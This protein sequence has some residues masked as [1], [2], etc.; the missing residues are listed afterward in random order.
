MLFKSFRDNKIDSEYIIKELVIEEKDDK[1]KAI[2]LTPLGRSLR[3]ERNL[4]QRHVSEMF[5]CV[6]ELHNFGFIHRD[7]SPSHFYITNEIGDPGHV[8]LIDLGSAIIMPF[9]QLNDSDLETSKKSSYAGSL[10]Y[11]ANEILDKIE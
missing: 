3:D 5:M 11:A 4:T 10:Q 1:H 7:L 6:R 2:V 9:E 8:F